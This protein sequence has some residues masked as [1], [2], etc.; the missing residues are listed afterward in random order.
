MFPDYEG[1]TVSKLQMVTAWTK[2]LDP[3]MTGHSARRSGAMLYTRM[4]LDVQTVGL[5]RP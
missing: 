4:G 2:H 1:R 5:R 3:G